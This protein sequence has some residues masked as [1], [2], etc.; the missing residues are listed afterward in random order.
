MDLSHEGHLTL[1]PRTIAL[2]RLSGSGDVSALGYLKGFIYVVFNRSPF[3]SGTRRR[4][5][6]MPCVPLTGLFMRLPR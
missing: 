2:P 6:A 5:G 3:T 1:P 4:A